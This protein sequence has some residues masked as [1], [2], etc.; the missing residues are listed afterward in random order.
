MTI[1]EAKDYLANLGLTSCSCA[2]GGVQE[3]IDEAMRLRELYSS[4]S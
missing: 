3:L 1:E 2:Y 4:S